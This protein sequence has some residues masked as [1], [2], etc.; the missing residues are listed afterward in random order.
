M[1]LVGGHDESPRKPCDNG[2]HTRSK[3]SVSGAN[4]KPVMPVVPTVKVKTDL[5]DWLN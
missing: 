4:E 5:I 2:L 3:P 1:P